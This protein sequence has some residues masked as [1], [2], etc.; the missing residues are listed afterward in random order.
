MAQAARRQPTRVRGLVWIRGIVPV[1]RT[2]RGISPRPPCFARALRHDDLTLHRRASRPGVA[3]LAGPGGRAARRRPPSRTAPSP[4]RDRHSSGSTASFCSPRAWPTIVKADWPA[5]SALMEG[6][7]STVMGPSPS[8][9]LAMAQHNRGQKK[10]AR[11]TLATAIVG[12]DWSAAQA[13]SRG[14]WIAHI[15]RREAEALILPNLPAFLRG[16]YQPQDNDE[17]LALVG[18]CEFEGRCHDAARLYADAFA[19]DPALANELMS[20]CRSRAV[21]GD[22]QPVSRVEELA[23]ECR[24]PAARCAALAGCGLG[25]TGPSSARRS[26]RTGASRLATG[27]GPTWPCG[28]RRWK[29][30]R[31]RHMSPSGNY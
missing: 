27:C 23:T 4:P 18:V 28:P 13:D 24:Y 15:L 9:I 20:T 8:L 25:A 31:G 12:F 11:K 29:V 21:L 19:T 30:D 22:K 10:Q 7:A 26:G 3:A 6:E 1:S 2:G 17:R 5:R 16:E 14:V